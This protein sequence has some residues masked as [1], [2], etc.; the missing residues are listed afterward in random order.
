MF[1]KFSENSH[2]VFVFCPVLLRVVSDPEITSVVKA[3]SAMSH[4]VS[5][6]A[7]IRITNSEVHARIKSLNS[8]CH[9]GINCSLYSANDT[10]QHHVIMQ[11]L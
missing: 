10:L 2:G 8:D 6:W 4:F 7:V 1:I 9:L 5:P 11:P 3:C